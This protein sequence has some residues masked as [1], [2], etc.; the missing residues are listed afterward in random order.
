MSSLSIAICRYPLHTLPPSRGFYSDIIL[1]VMFFFLFTTHLSY[2]NVLLIIYFCFWC[3]QIG[4]SSLQD[5]LCCLF[6]DLSVFVGWTPS[7]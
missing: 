7:S 2:L 1:Y 4:D 5:F 3:L 6:V